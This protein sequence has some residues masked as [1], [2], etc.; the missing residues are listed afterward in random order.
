MPARR[1]R[2]WPSPAGRACAACRRPA[3]AATTVARTAAAA[4]LFSSWVS[5]ADSAPR[6][7]SCSRWPTTTC[8]VRCCPR[9]ALEQVHRH[10]EP[11]PQLRAEL[12][13]RERN[14]R[15]V[16][17]AAQ[18]VGVAV[19][20]A[21]GGLDERLGGAGVGAPLVGA[22]D[23]DVVAA[24]PP[25]HDDRARRAA[26]RSTRPGR[27]RRST[28]PPAAKC[29]TRPLLGQPR[30]LLVVSASKR[31]NVR[32]SSVRLALPVGAGL[33]SGLRQRGRAAH[34]FSR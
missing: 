21:F 10:R 5:P 19:A 17:G 15:G 3:R 13:G 32:S 1:R 34:D 25:A 24:D 29:S 33:G 31:N 18:T 30:E 20:G 9:H 16:G 12:V 8:G 11:A 6:A 14:Q 22:D 4:G 23:L 27:P 28:T 7:T 26:R 2:C